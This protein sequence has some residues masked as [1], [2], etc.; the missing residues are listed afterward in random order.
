MPNI[1]QLYRDALRRHP[2]S[3]ED[4]RQAARASGSG[5][6]YERNLTEIRRQ[7]VINTA[8]DKHIPMSFAEM[9]L[10]D[11]YDIARTPTS[12]IIATMLYFYE[13]SK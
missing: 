7:A 12:E 11:C 5:F 9:A 10:R 6:E 4:K 8:F 3:E 13:S 1:N 2:F